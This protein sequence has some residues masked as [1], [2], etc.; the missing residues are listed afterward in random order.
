VCYRLAKI[1][2]EKITTSTKWF[3]NFSI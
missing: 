1:Y 2:N 3:K